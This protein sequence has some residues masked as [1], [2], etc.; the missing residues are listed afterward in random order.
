MN[1]V[2]ILI[3]QRSIKAVSRWGDL[4]CDDSI[5]DLE[6]QLGNP[7]F[8]GVR[9][10]LNL[11]NLLVADLVLKGAQRAVGVLLESEGVAGPEASN[12][13]NRMDEAGHI[14]RKLA[15]NIEIYQGRHE[16]GIPLEGPLHN[17]NSRERIEHRLLSNR[18]EFCS[19]IGH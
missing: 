13:E 7:G 6:V 18:L 8:V 12:V 5:A 3:R 1:S 2:L 19:K 15:G 4:T 10:A 11:E 9:P 17:L 16:G 14:L